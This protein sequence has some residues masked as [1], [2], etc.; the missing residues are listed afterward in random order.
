MGRLTLPLVF[1]ATSRATTALLI[2]LWACFFTYQYSG[3]DP[4][5][6]LAAIILGATVGARFWSK[7]TKKED[8]TSYSLYNVCASPDSRL[9][10][11]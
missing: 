6:L 11:Y 10:S 5:L 4:I 7:R 1:P 3:A 8:T 9:L 2:P